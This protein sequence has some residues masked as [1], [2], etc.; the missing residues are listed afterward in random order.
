MDK[1]RYDI[2]VKSKDYTNELL[3]PDCI[4]SGSVIQI[5]LKEDFD[6]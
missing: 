1:V 4:R 5:K 2:D 3:H 6:L